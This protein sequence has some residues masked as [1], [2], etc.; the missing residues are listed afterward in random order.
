MSNYIEIHIV[1]SEPLT[2]F[3]VDWA[4]ANL[5]SVYIQPLQLKSFC[6]YSLIFAK[7]SINNSRKVNQYEGWGHKS[8]SKAT[9]TWKLFFF[10]KRSLC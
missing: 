6:D 2:K 9:F 1:P 3:Q 10:N 8:L 5:T 7:V 4:F